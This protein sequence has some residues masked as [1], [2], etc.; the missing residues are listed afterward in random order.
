MDIPSLEQSIFTSFFIIILTCPVKVKLDTSAQELNLE[1]QFQ[2]QIVLSN[3]ELESTIP[4]LW[5]DLTKDAQSLAP[6]KMKD[7]HL[8]GKED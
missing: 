8:I 6:S 5:P 3:L 1:F 4:K 7:L 2:F